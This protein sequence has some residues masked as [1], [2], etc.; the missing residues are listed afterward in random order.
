MGLP[1]HAHRSFKPRNRYDPRQMKTSPRDTIAAIA[2]PLGEGGIGVIRVSGP[3]AIAIISKIFQK[4]KASSP[5]AAGGGPMDP[6]QKHSGMTLSDYPSH[7]CHVGVIEGE[8]ALDQVVVTLFRAP[9]SYTGEDVVE[10]SA[11]G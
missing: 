3:Q 8:T 10:I 4:N 2:T 1:A 5:A 7:T 11:H 9:H 6:R